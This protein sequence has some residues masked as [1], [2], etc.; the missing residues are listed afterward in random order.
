[1]WNERENTESTERKKRE[2]TG[3]ERR[4]RIRE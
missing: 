3:R 4:E 2:I 1:M